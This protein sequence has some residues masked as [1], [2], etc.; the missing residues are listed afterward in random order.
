MFDWVPNTPLEISMEIY[1]E[2]LVLIVFIKGRIKAVHNFKPTQFKSEMNIRN[3]KRRMSRANAYKEHLQYDEKER[4]V[5]NIV[6]EQHQLF[7]QRQN[8]MELRHPR[9]FFNPR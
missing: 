8:F 2:K 6:F 7:D 1:Q 4:K 5:K 3:I 9:H